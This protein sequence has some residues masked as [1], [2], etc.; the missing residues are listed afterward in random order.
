MRNKWLQIRVTTEELSVIKAAGGM[1]VSKWARGVLLERAGYHVPEREVKN[2][3]PVDKK[4]DKR[5]TIDNLRQIMVEAK[6]SFVQPVVP[7]RTPP[8]RGCGVK[9][10]TTRR[11]SDDGVSFLCDPCWSKHESQHSTN[12]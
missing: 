11:E 7:S 6:T 10:G 8:C 9:Y 1:D 5:T 2:L 4:D 3:G 12:Q